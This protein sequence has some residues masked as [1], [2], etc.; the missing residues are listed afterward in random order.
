MRSAIAPKDDVVDPYESE[1]HIGQC[2]PVLEGIGVVEKES[3]RKEGT[4]R[5]RW[6]LR[7]RRKSAQIVPMVSPSKTSNALTE[8]PSH[9]RQLE[10]PTH[11]PGIGDRGDLQRVGRATSDVVGYL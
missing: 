3:Y 2:A 10:G 6:V 7:D 9:E 8:I 5:P 11:V 4:H 1:V